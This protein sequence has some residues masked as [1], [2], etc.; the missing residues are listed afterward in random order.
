MN[1]YDE[2]AEGYSELHKEEQLKKV[3]VI[4]KHIQ[5]HEKWLILDVGCGPG[6]A[7]FPGKIIGIDPSFKLLKQAKIPAIQ[8]IGEHL[9]FKDNTF[10]AVVSITALQNFTD[11]KQGIIE[12]KRV[13]REYLAISVLKKSPK[14]ELI[15]QLIPQL[16]TV[17][18]IV[19]EEKDI[20]FFCRKKRF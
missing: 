19:E 13:A 9:P 3:A 18:R 6:F 17:Q 12:M 14:I 2:I 11:I 10:M 16:L 8:G 7:D 4:K 15:E 1:Y 20:I 5:F